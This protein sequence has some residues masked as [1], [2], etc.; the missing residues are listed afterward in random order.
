MI[1]IDYFILADA[2]AAVGGKHYIH[3]GGWDTLS[4]GGFPTVHPTM[5]VA[6]RLRVP[7]SDTNRETAIGLDLLNPK[8]T[9]ILPNP[10]GPL[11]GNISVGRQPNLAP[12]EAQVLLLSFPLNNLRFDT[13]GNYVVTLQLGGREVTRAPF[14][15]VLNQPPPADIQ[16]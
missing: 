9:S 12:G 5:A 14:R 16:A 1:Q 2:V 15:V 10:P 11:Q 4:T 13:P 3:G 7:W 6:V 8:G